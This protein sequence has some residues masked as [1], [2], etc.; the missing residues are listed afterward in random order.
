MGKLLDVEGNVVEV[1]AKESDYFVQDMKDS[2][3]M[4][5][6]RDEFQSAIV[7]L[8]QM[9]AT[10]MVLPDELIKHCSRQNISAVE[11]ELKRPIGDAMEQTWANGETIRNV[12]LRIVDARQVYE[13]SLVESVEE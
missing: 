8:D 4:W 9:L 3:K 6:I 12:L 11:R 2:S 1:E 10:M 7:T 5:D 13:Q